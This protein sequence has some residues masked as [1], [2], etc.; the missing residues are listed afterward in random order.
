MMFVSHWPREFVLSL[1]EFHHRIDNKG[2]K[3]H[4][5]SEVVF[6][7]ARD[8]LNHRPDHSLTRYR[9]LNNGGRTLEAVFP[10][11]NATA[12]DL[13]DRGFG[14]ALEVRIEVAS[15]PIGYQWEGAFS[16]SK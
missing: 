14:R 2:A 1:G 12:D 3:H 9:R 11:E 15:N 8:I 10:G 16:N 13:N 4:D 7:V 5:Q 6:V